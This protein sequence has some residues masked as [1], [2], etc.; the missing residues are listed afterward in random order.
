MLTL[1]PSLGGTEIH[2]NV[3]PAAGGGVRGLRFA[4]GP[5]HELDVAGPPL[6]IGIGLHRRRDSALV[7]QPVTIEVVA[8]GRGLEVVP[9]RRLVERLG[10]GTWR[11]PAAPDRPERR[12]ELQPNGLPAPGDEEALE[13]D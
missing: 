11:I 2:G 12:I 13:T 9:A 1:H 5:E 7:G 8:I 10:E 3:V 4:W 6:A